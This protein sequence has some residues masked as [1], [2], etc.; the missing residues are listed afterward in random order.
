MRT[1]TASQPSSSTGSGANTFA[2]D[3][4]ESVLRQLA[5]KAGFTQVRH[6]E[7]DNPFNRLYEF[8]R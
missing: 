6:V 7:M 2:D 3:L 1:E 5:G 8:A 4:P